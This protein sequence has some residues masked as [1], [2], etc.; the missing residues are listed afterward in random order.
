MMGHR[1]EMWL[2][3]AILHLYIFVGD[4][5]FAGGALCGV[6]MGLACW[7]PVQVVQV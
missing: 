1:P 4:A 3:L 2:L 6:L 5:V 7:T